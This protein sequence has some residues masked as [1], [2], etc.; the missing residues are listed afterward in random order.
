MTFIAFSTTQRRA[1][2]A[3][4]TLSYSGAAQSLGH[5]TKLY[6]LPHVATVV[7]TQG[8][9]VFGVMAKANLDALAEYSPDLDAIL[10]EAPAVLRRVWATE[11]AERTGLPDSTVYLVGYSPARETFA[12]HALT[13]EDEFQPLD[14]GH[15]HVTPSPLDV[16][17][18][19][20]ELGRLAEVVRADDLRTLEA[21]PKPVAP[22]GARGWV[23]LAKS[24]RAQRALAPVETGLKTFVGGDL[25]LTRL[26][27]DSVTTRKVHTFT[28]SGE[29]FRTM[30]A[31][32]YHPQA[33]LGPCPCG[34]RSRWVECCLRSHHAADCLCGSGETF[35]D[36]CMVT[37]TQPVA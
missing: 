30:I 16:R 35:R 37:D 29:E 5:T 28:D 6:P 33:Q 26:D 21:R 25:H 9:H 34:S 14:L 15:F 24:A 10:E 2:I 11:Q 13:S 22:S 7:L 31:G 19:D 36:C 4:D 8:D 32:T 17:P 12:A 18:S 3:T 23:D 1:D 27:R 20:I